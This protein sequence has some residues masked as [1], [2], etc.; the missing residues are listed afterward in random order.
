MDH[1]SIEVRRVNANTYD[2]FLGKQW[3]DHSRIRQTKHATF[4][5]SGNKLH[6]NVLRELHEVLA[7]NMP[8]NYGQNFVQTVFNCQVLASMGI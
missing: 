4:V 5:V 3:V 2:V 8:V 1:N 6:R 7:P